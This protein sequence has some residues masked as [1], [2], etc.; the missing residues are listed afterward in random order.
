MKRTQLEAV[1][2]TPLAKAPSRGDTALVIIDMLSDWDFVDADK[3][4]PGA[5]RIAPVIAGLRRR[6]KASGVPV[7]Y[8]NDNHGHWR[9]DFR[10]VVDVALEGPEAG[11]TICRQLMPQDDD[12]SVLKPKHSAF[13]E[14]PMALLLRHL[15]VTRLVVTGVSSDQCVLMTA[16]DARM[17]DFE[18]VVPGDATATQTAPRQ[19]L[20][21]R[22]LEEVLM[23]KSTAA[24]RVRLRVPRRTAAR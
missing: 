16:A 18:V 8:A 17:R 21:M 12:Y 15:G 3:L 1:R 6:C 10:R 11:A 9:S 24:A 5:A 4:L 19:A 13:Y 2:A 22:Y 20:A 14:T 7:I 23:I